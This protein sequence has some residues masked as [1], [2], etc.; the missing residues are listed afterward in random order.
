MLLG[1]AKVFVSVQLSQK[2]NGIIDVHSFF[3]VFFSKYWLLI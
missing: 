3:F 2:R 1:A